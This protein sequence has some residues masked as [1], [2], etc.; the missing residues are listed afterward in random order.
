MS[1][2]RITGRAQADLRQYAALVKRLGKGTGKYA[3]KQRQ[4][5]REALDR[6]RPAVPVWIMPI[7]RIAEQL[8]VEQDMF[9]VVFV[10][11]ASQAG[12]EAAFLQYL[13]PKIVVI[14][15]DKQVSPAAVGVA[16]LVIWADRRFRLGH[17][18][19]F[20][21]YV[22]AYTVGRFWIE[23]LRIDPAHDFLGLRI[24]EWTSVLVFLGAVAYFVISAR[25]HPGRETPEELEALPGI[26]PVTVQ[27]IVAARQEQ[28]FA[29][30]DDAVQRG[31]INRGQLEDI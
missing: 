8:R 23:G 19:A 2:T 24:N 3:A 12:L 28:P 22:A 26:G 29:S 9:D 20:A 30:L 15:D 13:A 17:G 1:E 11:E 27:K 4:E 16:V 31:V 5:I 10:D 21:L 18:R 25:R 7:Y 14:G 6:C